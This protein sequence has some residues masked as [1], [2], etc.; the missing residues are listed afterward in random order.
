MRR[1]LF[2]AVS[3]TTL[4]A[5]CSGTTPP[6]PPAAPAPK[7]A[8]GTFGVETTNI[9]AAVKPGDDFFRYANGKWLATFK[10]PADKARYGAFDA[11]GDKSESD[12][13]TVHRVAWPPTSRRRAP[14][15]PR[16]ATSTPAGW[17]RRRSRRAAS[18]R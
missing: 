8:L 10:M 5:G 7:A 2:L 12:V 14:T 9:D 1:V 4:L 13:K 17:T 3:A 18:S 6:P 15:P 16:S 11:L